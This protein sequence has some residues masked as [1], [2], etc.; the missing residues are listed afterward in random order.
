MSVMLLIP[1]TLTSRLLQSKSKLVKS[2]IMVGSELS[3]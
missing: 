1:S 3:E 2:D